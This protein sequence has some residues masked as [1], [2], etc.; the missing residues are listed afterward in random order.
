[1]KRIL[2]PVVFA[3]IYV[4]SGC[5]FQNPADFELP[6][7]NSNVTIPLMHTKYPLA[8]IVNDTTIRSLGDTIFVQFDGE[9][10]AD[11]I[12][13]DFLRIPLDLSREAESAIT[14]PNA[15]DFFEGAIL[16]ITLPIPIGETMDGTVP[17]LAEPGTMVQIPDTADQRITGT[18]WNLVASAVETA[19]GD[20]SIFIPLLDSDE[21]FGQIPFIESMLGIV[22][23]GADSSNFFQSSVRNKDLPLS[24]DSTWARLM[25]GEGFLARHD[26]AGIDSGETFDRTTS[27]V[28]DTLGE[29][30]EITFGFTL[31]R[32]A[33]SDTIT[34]PANDSL[35]M[36]MVVSFGIRDMERA[37]VTVSEYS[38]VPDLE[39]ISFED[40]SVSAEDCRVKGVYGG[41]FNSPSLSGENS[42]GISNV[43]STYPFD[44]DFGITFPNF[45]SP[46]GDTLQFGETL[47]RG[48]PPLNQ[49]QK[50]DSWR[51]GNPEGADLAVEEIGLDVTANTVP[52]TVEI[53]LDG[54]E[55]DWTFSMGVD[56]LPLSFSTLEANLD[57]PFPPQ[58]QEIEGIPQGFT[59]MSFGEII[60]R[61]TMFNQIRLPLFLDLDLTGFSS[62]GDSVSVPVEAVL[63]IPDT[64]EDTAK[65]IIRLSSVGTEVEIYNS[66]SHAEPDSSYAVL[67]GDT[68][69]T[70]VDLLAL[71]PSEIAVEATAGIDGRGAIDVNAAIWGEF[72]LKA[73]F[74]VRVD[75]ITF[76]PI[77]STKVEEMPHETRNQ[78]RSSVRAASL[79]TRVRNGLPLGGELAILFS[80]RDLFPLNRE[81]STLS[82]VRDSL[83]WPPTDS[84]YVVTSCS[85]LSP[86]R[87]D[88]HIFSVLS[89]STECF[90]GVAYLVRGVTGV[91]DTVYS[92]VDTLLKVV[93]PSPRSL[94][95]DTTTVGKPGMVK[96]PGDTTVVSVLDSNRI[97]LITSLG[98]HFVN[99]RTHFLGTGGDV[100]FLSMRD[101]LEVASLMSF[102]IESTGLLEEP[103]DEI[104]ITSPNGGETIVVGDTV[105]VRW[106]SLGDEVKQSQVEV[107][108]SVSDTATPSVDVDADWA[109]ITGNGAI[110]NVD[111]M[112]W[113]PTGDHV[114]SQRWLRVCTE[115]G[116]I[117]DNSGWYFQVVGGSRLRLIGLKQEE[118]GLKNRIVKGATRNSRQGLE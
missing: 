36:E 45:I 73:P 1:M 39:P 70:V 58:T 10:P 117:C 92:F 14:P 94:Y 16:S 116:S 114:G 60:L 8:D 42:I 11:S 46:S 41:T 79:T 6:T 40:A 110:A 24:V 88:I 19:L 32:A 43:I 31:Q 66:V 86:S 96:Q 72:T 97:K 68:A 29:T 95:S 83:G 84:L 80:D 67:V 59:G 22:I 87:G 28:G 20:T 17:N 38:L 53:F 50:L 23:G 69:A 99:T 102:L 76:V 104:V 35:N 78:L 9:L 105:V 13:E 106:R 2:I 15:A 37:L 47:S 100:V 63:G 75:P 27:L 3:G 4:Q 5:D 101:T 98:D 52:D 90:D 48:N 12:N 107:F 25:T 82:G 33:D 115:D 61:F 26:S 30:V 109:S 71:N 54:T 111:S 89:D 34:I 93:L 64:P 62:S 49:D 56:V 108:I 85:T 91:P 118:K 103:E 74:I 113:V 77:T 18:S 7:W 81:A 51:F 44:I 112:A 55:P 65:T 57:C 21:V